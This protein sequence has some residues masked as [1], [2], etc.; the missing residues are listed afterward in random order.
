MNG[1]AD[2]IM[3]FGGI[4]K[5]ATL[6][7]PPNCRINYQPNRSR[8]Q[9]L[10]FVEFE[11]DD[12]IGVFGIALPVDGKEEGGSLSHKLKRQR[13]RNDPHLEQHEAPRP[14]FR[15]SIGDCPNHSSE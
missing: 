1:Q 2:P 14:P 8:C 5:H 15:H 12:T 7:L 13:K 3:R 4:E 11:G 10:R 6:L 9:Q